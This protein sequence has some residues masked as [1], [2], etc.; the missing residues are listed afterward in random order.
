MLSLL[1][2]MSPSQTNIIAKRKV[3][4]GKNM[5]KFVF[6]YNMTKKLVLQQD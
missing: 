1:V 2:T 4:G 5:T 6:L 3:D